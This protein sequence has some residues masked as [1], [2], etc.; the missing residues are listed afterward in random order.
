MTYEQV[1]IYCLDIKGLSGLIGASEL[2]NLMMEIHRQLI[3]K[4]FDSL[5]KYV[6]TF[7]ETIDTLS[8]SIKEYIES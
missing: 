5:D 3:F 2:H 7:H 6:Q 4:K 8:V 1:S